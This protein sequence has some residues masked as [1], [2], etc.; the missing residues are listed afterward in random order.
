MVSQFLAT[1]PL[2]PSTYSVS[3]RGCA[4]GVRGIC[5]SIGSI[6]S[7]SSCSSGRSRSSINSSQLGQ[8]AGAASTVVTVVWLEN[9]LPLT[10]YKSVYTLS[11]L[12]VCE[13]ESVAFCA[14]SLAGSRGGMA[15]RLLAPFKGA[16]RMLARHVLEQQQQ[17]QQQH[18]SQ[19]QGHRRV[20]TIEMPSCCA[21][22]SG[23]H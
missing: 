9:I 10:A 17:S 13:R 6:V 21:I 2:R 7:S 15:V 18:S 20:D 4:C 23:R 1:A 3:V 19:Q 12:C 14:P 16:C 5:C 11:C 8:L 22:E